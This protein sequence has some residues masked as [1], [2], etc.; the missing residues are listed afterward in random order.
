MSRTKMVAVALLVTMVGVWAARSFVLDDSESTAP[1]QTS[2]VSAE[3]EGPRPASRRPC[4]PPW[5]WSRRVRW[6]VSRSATRDRVEVRR[7]R[8]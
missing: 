8:R 4:P 6:L 2:A 5:L 3:L 7:R 1:A